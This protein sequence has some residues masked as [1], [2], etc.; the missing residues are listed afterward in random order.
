MPARQV[1]TRQVRD[2][3][4]ILLLIA[5]YIFFERYFYIKL[6]AKTDA[7][8]M[9][10]IIIGMECCPIISDLNLERCN[11]NRELRIRNVSIR[12]FK[13]SYFNING[14]ATLKNLIIKKM[15]ALLE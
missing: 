5:L 4:Q 14:P 6:A 11:V 2:Q 10:L 8:F 1:D 15:R 3:G 12:K 9:D 7:N 13:A